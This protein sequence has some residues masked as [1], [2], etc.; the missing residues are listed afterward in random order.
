MWREH[1]FDIVAVDWLPNH[2]HKVEVVVRFKK[3]KRVPKFDREGILVTA[4]KGWRNPNN[5]FEYDWHYC[6]NFSAN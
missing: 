5:Q 2:F 6:T 3:Y 4:Y 1:Y